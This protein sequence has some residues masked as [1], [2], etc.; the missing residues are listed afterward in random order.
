MSQITE[1][2]DE[3]PN[4]LLSLKLLVFLFFGGESRVSSEALRSQS[5]SSFYLNAFEV[6]NSDFHS[7]YKQCDIWS[8]ISHPKN[9][10]EKR[11]PKCQHVSFLFFYK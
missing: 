6:K 5:T 3:K 7:G 11:Q 8:M 4:R 9:R 1:K 10:K 2:S